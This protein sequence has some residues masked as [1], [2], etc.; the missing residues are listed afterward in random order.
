MVGRPPGRLLPQAPGSEVPT[1]GGAAGHDGA[2]VGGRLE[3][4][5][6]RIAA[7]GGDPRTVTVVAVTKG[8]GADAAV[9][10]RQA[11]LDD[12]GENYAH[13]L[14]AK[15]GAGG[16]ATASCR[17]HFLGRVQRRQVRRIAEA[18]HLWQ[19][20]DRIAAGEEVAE[21]AP[22]AR[23]L[24]QVNLSGQPHRNG[25]RFDDVAPL[26]EALRSLGLDVCGLM[27]VG[28]GGPADAARPAFRRL[29]ALADRLALPERSIGMSGDLEV[30]VAEGSTMV[31]LG[32]ALFGPRPDRD[33]RRQ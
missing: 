27:G 4:A 17:W 21:R 23:V 31:R 16:A 33:R 18:V 3:V 8:F 30:A 5:R 24:V 28:P 1:P 20:V 13:E 10:A 15:W 22:G 12:L 7:A 9:A 14:E 19:A 32:R 2:T 6:D 25:C 29:V 11:G 26:V